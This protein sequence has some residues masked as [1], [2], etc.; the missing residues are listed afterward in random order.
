MILFLKNFLLRNIYL[1]LTGIFLFI[2]A[3][4]IN[5]YLSGNSNTRILRNSIESFLQERENDFQKL[6]R[7]ELKIR[8]LSDKN[9]SL[10]EL[11]DLMDKQYGI[12]I[13]E[14][15]H[16]FSEHLT[17]WSDQS[18]VLPDSFLFKPDG[19][20]FAT[21]SNG[22]F[23][24][25]K[26]SFNQMLPYPLT[27]LALIPVTMAIFYIY[28]KPETGFCRISL[29]REPCSHY[30]ESFPFSGKKQGRANAFLPCENRIL[31]RGKIQPFPFT[32]GLHRCSVAHGGHSQYGPWNC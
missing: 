1:I 29:G 21:L 20:Y 11:N 16:P 19:N 5:A 9:Y 17:F 24:I 4:G 28:R 25:I 30:F 2:A 10:T 13:Y 18:S 12:L 3:F 27:V 32:G 15:N 7:N 6:I 8:R 14:R 31:S 23:E 22:Q 26:H